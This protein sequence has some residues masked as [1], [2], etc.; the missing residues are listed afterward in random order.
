MG[1]SEEILLVVVLVEFVIRCLTA[2]AGKQQTAS[3]SQWCLPGLRLL[4]RLRQSK[5]FRLWEEEL[6]YVWRVLGLSG[7]SGPRQWP[8][9]EFLSLE[10]LR[11]F[12]LNTCHFLRLFQWPGPAIFLPWIFTAFCLSP[13]QLTSL[14]SALL[15]PCPQFLPWLLS[16]I[17][18]VPF[19]AIVTIKAAAA[20]VTSVFLCH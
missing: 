12:T 15:Q 3:S 11:L 2:R 4:W 6:C 20:E 10:S 7:F 16:Q 5:L 18:Q 9:L 13:S 8:M 14:S 19:V 1:A 17:V